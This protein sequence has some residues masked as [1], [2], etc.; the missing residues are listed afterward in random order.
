MPPPLS[1]QVAQSQVTDYLEKLSAKLEVSVREG[2]EREEMV[3]TAAKEG[4][5]HCRLKR[6]PALWVRQIRGYASSAAVSTLTIR[7]GPNF[8]S[9]I[10]LL[11]TRA[12]QGFGKFKSSCLS[13]CFPACTPAGKTPT[14]SQCSGL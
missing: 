7:S 10:L 13:T 14:D 6:H 12:T 4:P 1:Y 5:L 11:P 8:Y 3:V 2:R 9:Q